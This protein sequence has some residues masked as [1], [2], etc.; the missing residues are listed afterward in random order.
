M[1][2]YFAGSIRAGREDAPLYQFLIHHM[3]QNHTVLTEHIGDI[4]LGNMGES[5]KRDI[6]I[7]NRDVSWIEE[8]DVIVA[9]VSTPSLGV[10]Y[11]IGISEKLKKPVLCLFRTQNEGKKLSAMIQG[12]QYIKVEQ[13][14]TKEEAIQVIDLFL[15]SL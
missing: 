8:S 1:K 14:K 10:G 4:S 12:N 7:Y 9:E 13:Y 2:I 5:I 15:N 6:D 11:E 3:S